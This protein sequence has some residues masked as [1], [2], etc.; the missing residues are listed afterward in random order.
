MSKN[1]VIYPHPAS[2]IS[3]VTLRSVSPRSWLGGRVAKRKVV[4]SHLTIET[5]RS[6]RPC[7]L[8]GRRHRV[9][10]S[11]R[12]SIRSSQKMNIFYSKLLWKK[13]LKGGV[14][15][16]S[17]WSRTAVNQQKNFSIKCLL[18]G[19]L[20]LVFSAP[21]IGHLNINY[22]PVGGVELQSTAE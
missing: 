15:L 1:L 2:L 16:E 22:Q 19:L 9:S 13:T 18:Q 12:D 7:V 5:I 6:R 3:S 21:G 20:A 14:E 17:N 10:Y 11:A 8:Q 4:R